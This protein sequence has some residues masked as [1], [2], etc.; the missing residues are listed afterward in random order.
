MQGLLARAWLSVQAQ[1]SGRAADDEN[2]GEQ[3]TVNMVAGGTVKSDRPERSLD[4]HHLGGPIHPLFGR[5]VPLQGGGRC[6][7]KRGLVPSH[8]E[9]VP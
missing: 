7:A 3:S 6:Q 8:R 5:G 2:F 1:P 4:L 9:N